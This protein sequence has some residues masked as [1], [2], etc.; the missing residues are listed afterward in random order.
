MKQQK[1]ENKKYLIQLNNKNEAITGIK[2]IF[3]DVEDEMRHTNEHIDLF[4]ANARLRAELF[5]DKREREKGKQLTN[6]A[7]NESF[8]ELKRTYERK[9]EIISDGIKNARLKKA[10]A[11]L[12]TYIKNNMS[13]TDQLFLIEVIANLDDETIAQTLEKSKLVFTPK[14]D[15]MEKAFIMIN[16]EKYSLEIWNDCFQ[17]MKGLKEIFKSKLNINFLGNLCL[18]DLISQ[19]G[20]E[21]WINISHL[22]KLAQTN[23]SDINH[24][25]QFIE[26][27]KRINL[28][29][30]YEN[31]ESL[32]KDCMEFEN[33]G[34]VSAQKLLG[35]MYYYGICVI[36]DQFE[37]IKWIWL[38]A[39]QG[40]E[41][42][43]YNLNF[44]YVNGIG[45]EK[46]KIIK[47]QKKN[48]ESEHIN[49][50]SDNFLHLENNIYMF[51]E[52]RD[53]IMKK[54]FLLAEHGNI[55][56][57]VNLANACFFHSDSSVD[58]QFRDNIYYLKD[59]EYWYRRAAM[60]KCAYA[61]YMLGFFYENG[62]FVDKDEIQSIL[63]YKLS[64]EQDSMFV[65]IDYSTMIKMNEIRMIQ[66]DDELLVARSKT[67][68][69]NCINLNQE[70]NMKLMFN[71]YKL[72]SKKG[73]EKEENNLGVCYINGSGISKNESLGLNWIFLSAEKRFSLAQCNLGVCYTNGYADLEIDDT[74][75]A[76]WY[77]LAAAQGNLYAQLVL[78]YC[79]KIGKGVEKN[80]E[81]S[82]FFNTFQKPLPSLTDIEEF[83]I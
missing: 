47:K 69:H 32:I 13:Y 77:H 15:V 38:A 46:S 42:S 4:E 14:L 35:W 76:R 80:Q 67:S 3:V 43:Q 60:Q 70:R 19:I 71:H 48:I 34:N 72:A 39:N 16:A 59:A 52:M 6:H 68:G 9:I 61:Q 18:I 51:N 78:G 81:I 30:N 10:Y 44:C 5:K 26:L 82:D 37:S 66:R 27:T 8:Q 7:L 75:A 45:I 62:I 1:S 79:Y 24:I 11:L 28:D 20:N 21:K 36:K 58:S 25:V 54:Y 31:T 55:E 56:A 22:L 49:T 12:H 65:G 2:D 41:V 29:K 40:D 53:H 57:Q 50:E 23:I 74:E 64:I 33:S 73:G 83:L 17:K 63:L